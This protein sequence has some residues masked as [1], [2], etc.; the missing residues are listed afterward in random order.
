MKQRKLLYKNLRYYTGFGA[1]VALVFIPAIYIAARL[2]MIH[3]VDEY[4]CKERDFFVEKYLPALTK[5]E[6]PAWNHYNNKLII[7]PDMDGFEDNYFTSIQSNYENNQGEIPFRA[8]YSRIEIEGEKYFLYISQDMDEFLESLHLITIFIVLLAFCLLGGLAF[9]TRLIQGKLWEPFYKTLLLT[10]RFNIQH[11]E[12]PVFQPADTEEFD[13]LNNALKKLME[14]NVQSYKTQKE[15]TENASHEM[16][17]P[18]AVLRSNLDM[19]TQDNLTKEQTVIIQTLYKAISRM[20]H[21]NK[22]LLLL[23]KLDN[24]LFRDTQTIHVMDTVEASLSL[25]SGYAKADNITVEK[26]AK[27]NSLTVQANKQLFESLINNLLINAIKHNVKNG[28]ILIILED[29]RLAIINTGPPQKLD[30]DLLFRRFAR[31]NS[32]GCGLGMAIA[33]QICLL[34]GWQIAYDFEES[35]HRFT[36]TF[37]TK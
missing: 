19:L 15:F 6:I 30:S 12:V 24:R 5:S 2:Y 1:I 22:N 21:V 35:M 27:D 9:T 11:D 31:F 3:E 16:Q 17:T 14:E 36:V 28:V 25:L 10:E 13:Q 29:N 18:L 4:L 8:L 26:Q 32:I 33:K 20:T 34:Y 23:A 37:S 7:I